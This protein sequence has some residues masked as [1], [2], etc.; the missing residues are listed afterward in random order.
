MKKRILEN[1]N[2]LIKLV[3]LL[4]GD[5]FIARSKLIIEIPLP[6]FA[7]YYEIWCKMNEKK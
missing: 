1:D 7:E 5:A 4:N 3:K 2:P 6:K